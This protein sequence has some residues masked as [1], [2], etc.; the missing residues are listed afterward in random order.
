M[1]NSQQIPVAAAAA[2]AAVEASNPSN[3]IT[4]I[5][6]V[7]TEEIHNH[8]TRPREAAPSSSLSDIPRRSATDNGKAKAASDSS[9]DADDEEE[10]EIESEEAKESDGD[11]ELR[12]SW[13]DLFGTES[14]YGGLAVLVVAV[15]VIAV[16]VRVAAEV[17][18]S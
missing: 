7:P 17:F 9:T 11:S 16:V 8:R 14:D 4:Y 12:G 5:L 18:R 13:A 15:T 10:D 3:A 6:K 2:A 1:N